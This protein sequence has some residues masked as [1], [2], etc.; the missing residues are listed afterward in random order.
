M[1]S[2]LDSKHILWLM[3][4]LPSGFLGRENLPPYNESLAML[5]DLITAPARSDELI[6]DFLL[7][8]LDGDGVPEKHEQLTQIL[9]S[10][11]KASSIRK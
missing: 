1:I 7:D 8:K 11:F 6:K 3:L 10:A 2:L 9:T 5:Y 4:I